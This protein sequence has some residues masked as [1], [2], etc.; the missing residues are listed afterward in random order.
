MHAALAAAGCMAAAGCTGEHSALDPAGPVARSVAALWWIMLAGAAVLFAA[1]SLALAGAFVPAIRGLLTTTR[2]IAWGGLIIPS[3]VLAALVAAAFA[4]GERHLPHGQAALRIE[5]TARQFLW[6][7]RYPGG[8]STRD[9]LHV[10]AG[11]AIDVVVTSADVI[12][13]F[14]IP[15]LGGKIDAIPGHAN[16]IRLQADAPGTYGGLCAE[17]CGDGHTVMRFEAVAHAAA[18]YEAALARA[19][20]AAR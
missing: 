8:G 6:E 18:D 1:T 9:V 2:L 16:V 15:R 17:F 10:P 19:T 4:L 13:S 11:R 12:H 7:F 5:A 3:F 20:D 14:W